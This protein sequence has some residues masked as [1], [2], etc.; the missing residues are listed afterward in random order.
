MSKGV[1]TPPN[2]NAAAVNAARRSHGIMAI[3]AAAR[4]NAAIMAQAASV[5]FFAGVGNPY[6]ALVAVLR[7]GGV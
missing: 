4:M 7:R 3:R 5:A 6:A 1:P 2:R